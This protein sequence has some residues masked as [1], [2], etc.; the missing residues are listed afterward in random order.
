MSYKRPQPLSLPHQNLNPLSA[1]FVVHYSAETTSVALSPCEAEY[2]ALGRCAQHVQYFRQFAADIRFPH[3]HPSVILEHNQTA[4]NL[5]TAPQVTRK[6]RQIALKEH[7][8][9]FLHTSQQIT[10]KYIGTND[11]VANGLTKSLAPTKFLWFRQQLLNNTPTN[12]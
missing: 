10:P 8:I 11:M 2:L 12:D 3:H 9:R 1:P 5:T 7:Y 6:S 4:I